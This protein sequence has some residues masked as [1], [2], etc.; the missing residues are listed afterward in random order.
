MLILHIDDDD[1]HRSLG[2]LLKGIQNRRPIM[3][4]IAAEL[5]SM[6]EDNFESESW[7]GQKWDRS[8]R[9]R[10]ES[11]K[12]LQLSGILASS[13]QTSSGN[14]FARI[15]TNMKYAAIHHLGGQTKAHEIRAKNKKSLA[16]LNSGGDS[17]HV[18]SVQHP[19]SKI[20]AR[21]YLPIRGDNKLQSDGKKRILD[22]VI[23]S[24]SRSIQ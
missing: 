8:E 18:K 17:V 4:A 19:G 14:D 11:G 23:D 16:F 9:A 2:R 7:G 3:A 21:P 12:T 5:Q 10:S 1:F 20:P 22:V 6:T 13:I 24:L 15:G